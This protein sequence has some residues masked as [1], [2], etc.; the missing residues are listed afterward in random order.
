MLG[1]ALLALCFWV[2]IAS[3]VHAQAS[4][5]DRRAAALR[6]FETG[7]AAAAEE[8]W[9]DAIRAFREAYE[10]T[11]VPTALFNVGYALRAL[12]RYVEA[13]DAFDE[14]LG[15]RI[16]EETRTEAQHLRDEVDGRIGHVRIEGLEPDVV[17]EHRLD[18]QVVE[19]TGGVIDCDPGSHRIEVRREGYVGFEWSGVVGEGQERTIEA[20]LEPLPQ[21]GNIAE[22]PWLWIIVGVV[23]VGGAIT[24]GLVLDDQAQLRPEPGRNVIR[25]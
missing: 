8:R 2:S 19:E 20:S 11:G 24:V 18:G 17:Y 5:E 10:L 16:D 21:G 15:L 13:R 1:R 3:T 22:E 7:E 4:A 14:L 12:G 23:V 6:A 9:A 25:F